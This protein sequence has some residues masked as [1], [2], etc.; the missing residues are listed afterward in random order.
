VVTLPLVKN[1][2]KE[3][4][5]RMPDRRIK[6]A[7]LVIIHAGMLF[8]LFA[9]DHPAHRVAP[10][11]GGV[12]AHTQTAVSKALGLFVTAGMLLRCRVCR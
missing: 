7:K 11:Q 8:A 2:H 4:S 3:E 5:Q 10:V 1:K 12:A 6:G 9:G